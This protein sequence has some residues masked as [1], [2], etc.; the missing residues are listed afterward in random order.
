MAKLGTGSGRK[1]QFVLRLPLLKSFA[2]HK[3]TAMVPTTFLMK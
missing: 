2:I 1:R 3:R